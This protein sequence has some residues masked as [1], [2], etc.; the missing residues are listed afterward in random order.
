MEA[1]N[2]CSHGNVLII[3]AMEIPIVI[4]TCRS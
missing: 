1:V 4:H 3:Q 2:M